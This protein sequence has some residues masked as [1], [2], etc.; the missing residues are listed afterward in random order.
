MTG[1]NQLWNDREKSNK[2]RKRYAVY[3]VALKAVLNGVTNK[4]KLNNSEPE[5]E[6]ENYRW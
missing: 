4:Y 3:H 1:I 6:R 2:E 5:R